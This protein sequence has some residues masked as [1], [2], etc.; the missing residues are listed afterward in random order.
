M[1]RSKIERLQEIRVVACLALEHGL[2]TQ[3]GTKEARAE[4]KQLLTAALET[5]TCQA[6]GGPLLLPNRGTGYYCRYCQARFDRMLNFKS[7]IKREM[8]KNK[9]LEGFIKD[10]KA[11][12][13]LPYSLRGTASREDI[14]QYAEDLLVANKDIEKQ[15]QEAISWRTIH[16]KTSDEEELSED[17]YSNEEEIV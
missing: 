7:K 11:T 13:H 14:I 17:A 16:S 8:P 5:N 4:S 3:R 12:T 1:I 10:Y 9:A 15:M 6:C 2:G